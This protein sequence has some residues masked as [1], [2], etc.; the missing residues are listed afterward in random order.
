[1]LS[2]FDAMCFS[3][4][5]RRYQCKDPLKGA[6]AVEVVVWKTLDFLGST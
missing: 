1:M 6:E 3:P 5:P 2:C 4:Q